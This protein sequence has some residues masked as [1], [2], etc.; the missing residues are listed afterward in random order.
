MRP[1]HTQFGVAALTAQRL[2]TVPTDDA[3]AALGALTGH[4]DDLVPSRMQ[5]VNRI[6]ALLTQ[7]IAAGHPAWAHRR[8]RCPGPA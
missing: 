3:V 8:Q 7:I 5:T 6:D 4:R 1:T 2:N